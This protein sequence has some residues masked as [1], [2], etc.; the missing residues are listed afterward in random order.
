M[1]TGKEKLQ[2]SG[3]NVRIMLERKDITRILWKIEESC[4]GMLGI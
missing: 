2:V 3:C 4:S 1:A